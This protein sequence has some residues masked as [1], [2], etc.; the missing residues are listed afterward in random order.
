[1]LH[2]INVLEM[3]P[4]TVFFCQE[5]ENEDTVSFLCFFHL[6]QERQKKLETLL[7]FSCVTPKPGG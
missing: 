6:V 3:I 4:G 7:L 1:M 5:W 2:A